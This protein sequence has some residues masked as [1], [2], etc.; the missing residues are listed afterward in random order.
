M[1][2]GWTETL[3]IK[4]KNGTEKE[5]ESLPRTGLNNDLWG[6]GETYRVLKLPSDPPHWSSTGH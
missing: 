2:I 5:I 6:I 3:K 4:R 1:S